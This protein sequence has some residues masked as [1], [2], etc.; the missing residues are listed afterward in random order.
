MKHRDAAAD[1]HDPDDPERRPRR[2]LK[3][4]ALLLTV[5]LVLLIGE[6]LASRLIAVKLR[7]TVAA[8]LDAELDLGPLLYVPPFGAWTWNGR[9]TRDGDDLFTVSSV[10]LELAEFPRKD[11]PIII[12]RLAAHQPV[13]NIAPRRFDK[14][15]KPAPEHEEDVPRKL[16]GMLRLRHVRV[17]DGQVTYVDPARPLAPPTVWGNLGL[18]VDT[19]Q[20]SVS[21][22]TFHLVSRA[23]PLAE[24]TATGTVDVD[25]G[26]LD[27]QSSTMKFRA[28]PEPVRS[29]LPAAAQEFIRQRRINGQ[30][31][32]TGSGKVPLRD[33][34]QS[35][36]SAAVAL[37]NATAT[38]PGADAKLEHARANFVA[39][40]APGGPIAVRV[41]RIDLSGS[42]RQVIVNAGRAEL[43]PAAGTWSVADIDGQLILTPPPTT[44][45]A[46]AFTV[47][48]KQKLTAGA[49]PT[50]AAAAA[51]ASAPARRSDD[52]GTPPAPDSEKAI[53]AGRADFT[54]AASGPF[55]L[56]GKRA[57]EAI[58]HEVILYPR[59]AS[60]RPKKFA[61]R[62]DGIG[63]GEIRIV[64]GM[65]ICQELHGHYG[66]DLLRLR[67]ARL[68]MADLPQV[69]RWQEISGTVVFHRP[70]RPYT[71][72]LDKILDALDPHGPFLIAGSWVVDKRPQSLTP[73]GRPRNTFDLIISS[74]TGSFSLTDRE[75]VLEKMRG[76]ATVTNA[77]VDIH[78]LEASVFDGT[79]QAAGRWA[80]APDR[81]AYEG[82]V[83]LRDVDIR[84]LEDRFRGQP[85]PRP[86]E[87]RL[88][89]SGTLRGVVTKGA[90]KDETL[91]AIHAAGEME[92]VEGSLFK[93]PVV[94]NVT[95]Q[96]KGLKGAANVGDAA[97]VFAIEDGR[98]TLSDAAVSSPVVGLQG[99][100]TL[101]LD[102]SAI[103]LNVVAAPLADWREN[104]KSTNIPIVSDVV[105]EVAGG[106]QKMLNAAT[107]ALLYQFR[108]QGSVDRPEIIAVPTPVLTDTAAFV[109]GKMLSPPKKDQRPIDL[110][111]RDREEAPR[112]ETR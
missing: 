105:G 57:I 19:I 7:S 33:P 91:R 4:I 92:I 106:I 11:K 69:A 78:Q 52:G 31:H 63:G 40:M 51:A 60:F 48:P 112:A 90:P 87:G 29:P 85:S 20:K 89:A 74:D 35:N 38:L 34:K 49:P 16:S 101:A 73:E 56:A 66:D 61:H 39:R 103:D 27:I 17:T 67:S 77:G 12:S 43:N 53:V 14:I 64:D 71:E 3:I 55:K 100:G 21:R 13:I 84:Q 83:V 36:F 107:G 76:D 9:I 75:V 62:I 95:E 58:R 82:E 50:G 70:V 41:D 46:V 110:I 88:S 97:A 54:A 94:K 104:L 65:I 1:D 81:S 45:A 18:D 72:K 98:V 93:M 79:L 68:P 6:L 2:R 86:L 25:D 80:R 37:Q 108:V 28:E 111:R 24:V 15:V 102:G 26:L 109:F 42:G 5:V 10:R 59:E 47:P 30:V 44:A 23:A 96:V 32:I 99:G 22:Y 8:K